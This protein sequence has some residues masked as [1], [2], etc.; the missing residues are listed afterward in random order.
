MNRV[1]YSG[2]I[3]FAGLSHL[4]IVSS[5]CWSSLGWHVVGVDSDPDRVSVLTAGR[6]PIHEPRLAELL[7]DTRSRLEFSHEFSSLAEC[8]VVVISLDTETDQADRSD[9]GRLEQLVNQVIPC[10]APEASVVLMSQ[11]PLGFTRQLSQK[12]HVARPDLAFRLYYWVETLVIGNAVERCLKPERI[13]LGC[14]SIGGAKDS[15]LEALLPA[16]SCPV[17][18]MSYESAELTKAAINLYLSVSVTYANVLADLCEATGASMREVVPALRLD[19]RIGQ[20]AYIRSGLG[21]A[22]GNLERDLVHLQRLGA[23]HDTDTALI[24]YVLDYNAKRYQW[25]HRQLTRHVFP[26]TPKPKIALWGLAYKKNTQSTKNSFAVRILRDLSG[27]AELRAYDPVA[28]LPTELRT[29]VT[30]YDR[31]EALDGADCLL[32]LTDWDEFADTD[33][34]A[35]ADKMS[36]RVV[37]DCV[38]V[39][40]RTAAIQH[41][42]HFIS[43]GDPHE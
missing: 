28:P 4:G 18:R 11:V 14:D 34:T 22:G 10:L 32:V 33:Y 6:L 13:I 1:Q 17:L 20:Y 23:E 16:F 39:L 42:F 36:G 35:M 41:G 19:R 7:R 30:R 40:D 24:D 37:I 2:K 21:I 29:G 27:Q 8:G 31:F 5:I 9:L 43:I 15:H 3:G 25:V 12:L 26:G 38:G